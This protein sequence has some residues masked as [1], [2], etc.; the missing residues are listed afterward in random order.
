MKSDKSSAW[1]ELT[2]LL[3]IRGDREL[4]DKILKNNSSA[5]D[6]RLCND[7]PATAA[8]PNK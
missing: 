4:E 6:R 1:R 3:G 8:N 7:L 2:V 5:S